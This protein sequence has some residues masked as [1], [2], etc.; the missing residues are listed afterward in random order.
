LHGLL[1]GTV[2]VVFLLIF[3][4]LK[5]FAAAGMDSE[6]IEVWD[7]ID[8]AGG[9]LNLILFCIDSFMKL[10]TIVFTNEK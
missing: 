1:F 9:T 6:K 8:Y 10:F 3:L 5:V 4:L 2:L 7:D